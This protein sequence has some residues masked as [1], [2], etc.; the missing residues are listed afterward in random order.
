MVSV[1]LEHESS[2][3]IPADTNF[4]QE[5]FLNSGLTTLQR[6]YLASKCIM[7]DLWYRLTEN[8]SIPDIMGA[9]AFGCCVIG[10]LLGIGACRV[11]GLQ[12]YKIC[13]LKFST[14]SA[15][16]SRANSNQ[17]FLSRTRLE[18]VAKTRSRSK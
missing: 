10:S 14:R 3:E 8:F 11:A 1:R 7:D 16:Q 17:A 4:P 15:Q 6:T 13:S 2:I 18:R 9:F 5:K 12:K